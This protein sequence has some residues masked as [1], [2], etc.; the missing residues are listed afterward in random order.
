MGFFI[1]GLVEA[2]DMSGIDHCDYTDGDMN[3]EFIKYDNGKA[4]LSILPF[5][6]LEAIAKIMEYGAKE[7]TC[8][9]WKKCKPEEV[10]RYIDAALRHIYQSISD[11]EL[12]KESG[13]PHIYHAASNLIFL[14]YFKAK[15][16]EK[17]NEN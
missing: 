2:D 6:A 14:S 16:L 8:D 12:D 1:D 11:G 13:F 4:P 17:K 9:N 15:E 7:Y 5:E 3:M 10:R